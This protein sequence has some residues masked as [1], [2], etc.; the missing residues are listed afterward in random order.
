MLWLSW[1]LLVLSTCIFKPNKKISSVARLPNETGWKISE[2]R[3][4]SKAIMDNAY[5]H[6]YSKRHSN[7]FENHNPFQYNVTPANNAYTNKYAT[8]IAPHIEKLQLSES[9]DNRH[10]NLLKSQERPIS[11]SRH[12]PQTLPGGWAEYITSPPGASPYYYQD[13]HG[14]GHE[15]N[16]PWYPNIVKNRV[17]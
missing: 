6:P 3:K 7:S 8:P 5:H 4:S 16:N 12:H 11:L 10:S 15:T 1:I 9:Y 2:R 14:G 17:V 13:H